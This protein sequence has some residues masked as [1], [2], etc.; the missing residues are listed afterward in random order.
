MKQRRVVASV[1]VL[2]AGAAIAA[3]LAPGTGGRAAAP[4]GHVVT[5]VAGPVSWRLT[6][7][8]ACTVGPPLPVFPAVPGRIAATEVRAGDHVK[9]GDLIARIDPESVRY[10]RTGA[11][12][13][14][15]PVAADPTETRVLS[16]VAGKVEQAPRVGRWYVP[17]DLLPGSGV[18]VATIAPDD[19]PLHLR[20]R[21][22]GRLRRHVVLWLE[23]RARAPGTK[24]ADGPSPD[25]A[26]RIVGP[27]RYA[28]RRS[29]FFP[30]AAAFLPVV[31]AAA[32]DDRLL[33]VPLPSAPHLDP[34]A[35]VEV[36]LTLPLPPGNLALPI[37]AVR[38]DPAGACVEVVGD[39]SPRR[40]TVAE[41]DAGH[42][43]VTSGLRAGEQVLVPAG[44]TGP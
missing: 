37:E 31:L 14:T 2:L 30:G 15:D 24:R 21:L 19:A 22:G 8:A 26:V 4:A 6:L 27:A 29:R 7:A 23:G 32:E 17:S 42:A 20:T 33:L 28:T 18:P 39:R 5:A 13:G 10:R 36:E 43:Y 1:L 44:R 3:A 9:A 40:V 34:G 11:A 16:P 12:A 25:F 35:A 41:V 38:T